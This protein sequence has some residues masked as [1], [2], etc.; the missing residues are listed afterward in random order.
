MKMEW[1]K[2]INGTT[3]KAQQTAFGAGD[4][5]RVWFKILE[6][7]KE[8]LG[9]FEGIVIRL[10]GSC[11]SKTFTVRRVTYGEGVERIFPM[12]AKIISKIEVLSRARVKRARLYFLRTA[13]GKIRLTKKDAA[14]SSREQASG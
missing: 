8:R 6:H 13:I 3:E 10:R 11:Q 1:L 12:D 2:F 14:S 9:Q 4:E 5:V 7:G